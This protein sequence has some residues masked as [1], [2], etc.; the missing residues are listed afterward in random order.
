MT[1]VYEHDKYV[2]AADQVRATVAK[3][4]VAIVDNVLDDEEI[5]A[6]RSGAWTTLAHITQKLPQ[7]EIIREDN[8]AS[9]RSIKK[10]FPL[11]SM[12]IQHWGIGHAQF[13]WDLRENYKITN[14]FAKIWDCSRADLLCSFDGI[15]FHMPPET[16][17]IGWHKYAKLG[18]EDWKGLHTDQSYLRNDFECIQSWVTAYDVNEGDATLSFLEGSHKLH[19]DFVE[20]YLEDSVDDKKLK[21]DW[22]LL[23]NQEEYDFYT[24]EC[25]RRQIKCKAGSMVFWDSRTIHKGMEPLKTRKQ[26]NFRCVVY[27]C[28]QPRTPN[29]LYNKKIKAFEEFRMTSHWPADV[30]LFP[31]NPRTYGAVV[32]DLVSI[33]TPPQLSRLGQRLAG[34]DVALQKVILK[35]K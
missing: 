9:W 34:Y 26:P 32:E 2:C 25:L 22:Y 27:I 14:I 19:K 35:K 13:V 5:M 20:H 28:M 29:V 21:D 8:P 12:L 11:H 1:F 15:S 31:K 33:D 6:M 7:N 18:T 30:K 4:G 23:S 10:L 17:N 16:T 3:Y 24:E